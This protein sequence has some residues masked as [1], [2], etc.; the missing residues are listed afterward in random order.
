LLELY[1][2]ADY[3]GNDDRSAGGGLLSCAGRG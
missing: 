3:A 2:L 1:S